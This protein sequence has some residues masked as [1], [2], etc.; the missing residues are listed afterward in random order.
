MFPK[1]IICTSNGITSEIS[2]HYKSN[3]TRNYTEST[4]ALFPLL[5]VA[6]KA[7]Y[8]SP[9]P[10]TNRRKEGNI[11]IQSPVCLGVGYFQES[12]TQLLLHHVEEWRKWGSFS[13][14]SLKIM[15][16]I[17]N[18]GGWNNGI[19]TWHNYDNQI[20]IYTANIFQAKH[21]TDL[22]YF[23]VVME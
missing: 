14:R 19:H 11:A 9:S 13:H 15:P 4:L 8:S 7:E 12:F 23:P 20:L 10:V 6:L 17:Y 16:P 2:H 22:L 1:T 3:R 5:C 18:D 21:T